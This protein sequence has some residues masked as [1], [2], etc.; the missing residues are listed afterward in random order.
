M[1]VRKLSP[2]GDFTFGGGQADYY[3]DQAEAVAQL[4][5][6]RLLLFLGEWFLDIQDGT[7]WRTKVLGNR[8]ADTRDAVIRAR[9]LDTP[10][11]TKITT[12]DSRVDRA[13][14]RMTVAVQIETIYGAT[15]IEAL[16]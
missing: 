8:T 7:P 4:A 2:T 15:S 6:T 12:Y 14:R 3:R 13:T 5:K 9:I 10:G 16:F 11:V 1:R